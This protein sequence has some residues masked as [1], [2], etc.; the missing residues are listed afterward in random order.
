M[1]LTFP[2]CGPFYT[3]GRPNAIRVANTEF[4]LALPHAFHISVA[5]RG[6]TLD[7]PQQATADWRILAY[8]TLSVWQIRSS[9]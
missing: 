3:S 6:A 9:T 8:P 4:H 7:L 5:N 1:E 2:I